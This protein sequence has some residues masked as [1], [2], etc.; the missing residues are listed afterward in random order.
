M[1]R[2]PAAKTPS[3]AVPAQTA[4]VKKAAVPA[5]TP[6]PV[7]APADKEAKTRKP[8][9]VRDGFTMPKDEYA[10]IDALKQRAATLGRPVKKSELLRAGL[11]L[12][13]GLNDDALITALQ[14]LTTIKTGRPK[15]ARK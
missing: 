9:L 1:P 10:A 7:P 14:A 6:A 15:A 2:T 5:P 12:L 3:K 8:K 11:K 13:L 4:A